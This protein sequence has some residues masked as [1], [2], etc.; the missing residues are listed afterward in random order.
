MD[1]PEST[2]SSLSTKKNSFYLLP[3]DFEP[4][5]HSVV[6]GR[7]KECSRSIGN[8]RLRV[9]AMTFLPR[10]CKART[11]K[12]K[13]EVVSQIVNMIREAC[14]NGG[15]FIKMSDDGRW[16]EWGDFL[17][18]EKVGY[19]LRDLLHTRYRSSSKS[20]LAMRRLKQH[21][22]GS[23]PNGEDKISSYKDFCDRLSSIL[24]ECGSQSGN[25][26]PHADLKASE[27]LHA[28]ESTGSLHENDSANDSLASVLVEVNQSQDLSH[29]ASKPT[30]NSEQKESTVVYDLTLEV[31]G[32]ATCSYL[33]PD[34]FELLPP[35]PLRNQGD[36][37][38]R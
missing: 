29:A 24:G 26:V 36:S 6:L 3:S 31:N 34:D 30:C 33:L 17:A 2:P 35:L 20:K 8:R 18:R 19:V 37:V 16:Q 15:A 9:L 4:T 28:G 22:L 10:Y 13:S 12:D 25:S 38:S 7:G 21:E 32:A 14:P 11:R 23:L 5:P 27:V 1:R